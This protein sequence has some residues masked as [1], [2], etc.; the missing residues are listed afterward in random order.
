MIFRFCNSMV[1]CGVL[2][3]AVAQAGDQPKA[4][5]QTVR[6][7]VTGLFQPDRVDDLRKTMLEWP[8]VTLVNVDFDAAEAE[9]RFDFA[10]A[11]PN[12]KQ[13]Q[14]VEAL[15]GKLNNISSG[16]F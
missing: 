8:E 9:F 6:L 4:G 12:N 15:S 11:F 2:M 16:T 7:R 3:V 13:N 14:L 1:F 10:K 5:E